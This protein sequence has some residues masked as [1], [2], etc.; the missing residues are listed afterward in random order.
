M[1]KHIWMCDTNV[2]YLLI[3]IN[4]PTER[5]IIVF[6]YLKKIIIPTTPG[7]K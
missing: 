6:G 4:I 3:L 7:Y 5:T 2:C 1:Y